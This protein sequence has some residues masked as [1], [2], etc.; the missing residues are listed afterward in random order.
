MKDDFLQELQ[1]VGF[2]ARMKRISDGL[3]YDA[4]KIYEDLNIGIEPNWH[5]IFLLLKKEGQLTVTE[6]AQTLRFSHPAII[7]IIKKMEE[8]GFIQRIADPNDS[9]K[10]LLQLSEKSIEMLPRFEE[11]WKKIEEVIQDIVDDAFLQKL[12]EVEE[13]LQHTSLFT[14]YKANKS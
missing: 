4:R 1:F 14:G 11:E 5:L 12:A 13:K 2:T 9:R 8:K 3:M 7:K 6:I 10:Q